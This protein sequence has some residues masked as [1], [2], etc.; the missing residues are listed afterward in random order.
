MARMW[1]LGIPRSEAEQSY[2]RTDLC[3]LATAVET[4]ERAGPRGLE[5][6]AVLRSLWVDTN[7]LVVRPQSVDR[8]QRM[9]PGTHYPPSCLTAIRQDQDGVAVYAP[10][11]L[12]QD[13]NPYL[14]YIPGTE[15]AIVHR[16]AGRPIYL[17]RRAGPAIG[18]PLRFTR[19]LLR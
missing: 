7:R 5:A 2:R 15:A 14:R 18:A 6:A 13:G 16:A 17:L 4:L 9:V 10:L 12:V 3:A 8:T 11:M 1:A 19:L